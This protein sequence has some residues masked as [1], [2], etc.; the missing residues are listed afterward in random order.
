MKDIIRN[1]LNKASEE[2]DL[3]LAEIANDLMAELA[4]TYNCPS[5][6]RAIIEEM[7]DE[8]KYN[9]WIVEAVYEF[10]MMEDDSEE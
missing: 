4:S 10:S 1:I 5:D 6:W 9:E 7:Y 8:F 2:K 3:T